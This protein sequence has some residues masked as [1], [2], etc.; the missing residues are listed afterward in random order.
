MI[1]INRNNERDPHVVFEG[2]TFFAYRIDYWLDN[3]RHDEEYS[4]ISKHACFGRLTKSLPEDTPTSGYVTIHFQHY[5]NIEGL[6][7][8]N[9]ILKTNVG[10]LL[11]THQL[12]E[13]FHALNRC[14]QT[15]VRHNAHMELGSN[16]RTAV[17]DWNDERKYSVFKDHIYIDFTDLYDYE[18]FF[19]LNMYRRLITFDT[20][21][22]T[23]AA[24]KLASEHWE[25][26]SFVQL[27]LLSDFFNVS[28]T[29]IDSLIGCI[30]FQGVDDIISFLTPKKFK[31]NR[32]HAAKS[33]YSGIRY[34]TAYL[35]MITMRQIAPHERY[36]YSAFINKYHLP[37]PHSYDFLEDINISEAK[38]ED[39]ENLKAI[40]KFLN[41]LI[42]QNK[43]RIA[44][45][46]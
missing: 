27:L 31:E 14:L 34:M 42:K 10:T 26:L 38:P 37:E 5:Y 35:N 21:R 1:L 20:I 23:L 44:N 3:K 22:S 15:Y 19:I 17:S 9:K 13:M 11:P 30:Y 45:E 7:K 25:R 24:Y 46:A 36:N 32:G 6:L 8:D 4:N 18:I 12:Y 2:S 29:P 28:H 39:C 41:I 43:K 40:Y 33:N 16:L